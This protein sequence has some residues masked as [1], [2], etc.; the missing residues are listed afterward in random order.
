MVKKGLSFLLSGMDNLLVYRVG[1]LSSNP[2]KYLTIMLEE[3]VLKYTDL[4][5]SIKNYQSMWLKDPSILSS[6]IV[7]LLCGSDGEVGDLERDILVF[8]YD[9]EPRNKEIVRRIGD[10]IERG[11]RVVI[12]PS[13]IREK[14][15]NDMVLAGH[16]VKKL[17]EC[18]TYSG[19]EAKLKFTTWKKV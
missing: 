6:T 18:N 5:R 3:D 11:E 7:W 13:G 8:V 1:P 15:I 2:I 10:C 17:V 9:N 16:D 19:L 4:T 12:W 14:D